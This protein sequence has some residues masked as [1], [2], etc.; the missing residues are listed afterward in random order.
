MEHAEAVGSPKLLG[1]CDEIKTTFTDL[2]QISESA[3]MSRQNDIAVRYGIFNLVSTIVGGGLLSLPYAFKQCGLALGCVLLLLTASLS[4]YT[5][6][7]LVRCSV[8]SGQD[9]YE[10]I[11]CYAFGNKGSIGTSALLFVLTWL[12]AVAYVILLGDIA[13][14]VVQLIFGISD[15]ARD[16]H[17]VLS[18]R[19]ALQLCAIVLV[20]PLTFAENLSALK[21][22]SLSSIL[23]ITLLVV[24]MVVNSAQDG[25]TFPDSEQYAGHDQ[26]DVL[27]VGGAKSFTAF[28]IISVSFLCHFNVLPVCKAV[29]VVTRTRMR[30]L[31]YSTMG[32][33]CTLYT[34]AAV[35]GY[36]NFRNMVCGNVLLNYEDSSGKVQLITFGRIG[37]FFTVML[38]FPLLV[39]PCRE[40]AERLAMLIFKEPPQEERCS[41]EEVFES[42]PDAEGENLDN[43]A[44]PT[45]VISM[46]KRILHAAIINLSAFLSAIFIPGV[47]VVWTFMGSTVS[48]IIAFILPT[49]FY[50]R[51][52]EIKEA[53]GALKQQPGSWKK[54]KAKTIFM[55]GGALVV[56]C[57]SVSILG[58]IEG[59]SAPNFCK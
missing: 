27:W 35:F 2:E 46:Q 51:I 5:V 23:S 43:A 28:S 41:V 40:N 56:I 13:M 52:K 34:I 55:L 49:A 14:P 21:F 38:T 20:C 47:Q 24:A 7:L 32:L 25:F 57:T 19:T 9:S 6:K 10:G 53:Q 37:L 15:D 26:G 39:L 31:V 12:C 1:D 33:C 16:S 30:N 8:L 17:S 18:V 29:T 48:I 50:L 54:V 44:E 11:A 3:S 58:Q 42:V 4:G 45:V 59:D 22:T 36:L